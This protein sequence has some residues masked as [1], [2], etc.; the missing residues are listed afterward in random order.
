MEITQILKFDET[1]IPYEGSTTFRADAS[2]VWGQINPVIESMNISISLTNDAY[3]DINRFRDEALN[4]SNES[5]GARNSSQEYRDESL[6]YRNEA[7]S[8]KDEISEYVIP[9]EAT[10]SPD[11][12]NLLVDNHRLENFL[13]FNF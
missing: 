8:A 3:V 13:G 11:A 5:K 10:L 6:L 7:L 12:I 1:R 9:T 4:Y 2:Y